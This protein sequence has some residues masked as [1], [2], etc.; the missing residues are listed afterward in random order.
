M[1]TAIKEA[2][3]A[4]VKNPQRRNNHEPKLACKAPRASKLVTDSKDAH[5][6]WKWC[7]KV[8][9]EMRILTEVEQQLI[10]TYSLIYAEL[11]ENIRLLR[12]EG[13]VIETAKG[14]TRNPRAAHVRSLRDQQIKLLPEMGLTPSSRTRL[15]AAP[16]EEQDI[17][18]Q[19]MEQRKNLN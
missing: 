8:M 11:V 16:D 6:M 17:F 12:E 1:A 13:S 14:I 5:R 7:C 9:N 19:L 4:F 10:E 18:A 15:H 3:G 2:N